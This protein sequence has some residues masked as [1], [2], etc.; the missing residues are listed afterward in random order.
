MGSLNITLGKVEDYIEQKLNKKLQDDLQKL[1]IVKEAD[2]ECCA[3]FHLRQY[4]SCDS[5]WTILARKHS[6]KTQHYIDLLLFRKYKPI[7]AIELK[8]N[9]PSIGKK[10]KQ[11]LSKSVHKLHVNRAYFISTITKDKDKEKAYKSLPY[12]EKIAKNIKGFFIPL[13]DQDEEWHKKWHSN[14]NK[15][16]SEITESAYDESVAKNERAKKKILGEHPLVN[17]KKQK[18]LCINNVTEMCCAATWDKKGIDASNTGNYTFTVDAFT[19]SIE[20]NP[21]DGYTY[22]CRAGAYSKLSEHNK[23]IEDY[24]KAIDLNPHDAYSH[25]LRGNEYS[26]LGDH[27]KAME[28]FNKMI[29]LYPQLAFAYNRRGIAYDTIGNHQRAIE[30]YSEAIYLKPNYIAPYYNRALAYAKLEQYHLSM[31]DLNKCISLKPDYADAYRYRGSVYFSQGK[32]LQ[33]HRDAIKAAALGNYELLEFNEEC[34]ITP[35]V[36]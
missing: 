19:K 32:I 35:L 14:K 28:D 11:S 3:Y 24:S 12:P 33:C 27:D 30:D 15:Y 21:H 26:E 13:G 29:E 2:L 31:E 34:G 25:F 9:K 16:T 10:D 20:L 36:K 8:W 17:N 18:G 7:I 1:K 4:L 5:S 6:Q 23:A 22:Y